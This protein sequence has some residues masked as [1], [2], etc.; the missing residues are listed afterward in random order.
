MLRPFLRRAHRSYHAAMPIGVGFE[1]NGLPVVQCRFDRGPR[2]RAAEKLQNVAAMM[3]EIHVQAHEA[4][5]G[6]IDAEQR[7][8]DGR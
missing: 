8:E 2:G 6:A 5:A 7:I 4:I 3:R 1:S